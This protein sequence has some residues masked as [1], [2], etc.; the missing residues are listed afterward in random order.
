[1]LAAL[2]FVSELNSGFS[3]AV[4]KGVFCCLV[5]VGGDSSWKEV[6]IHRS[7][8]LEAEW[9]WVNGRLVFF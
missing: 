8:H 5:G 6:T 4:D 7:M 9:V 1:M 2:G 3:L